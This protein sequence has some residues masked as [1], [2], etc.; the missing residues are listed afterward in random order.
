MFGSEYQYCP[1]LKSGVSVD[2]TEGRCRDEHNCGD[3]AC[4]LESEFV[5]PKFARSLRLLAGQICSPW[6]PPGK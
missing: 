2:Q 1:N 5:R 3:A 4:P 6:A